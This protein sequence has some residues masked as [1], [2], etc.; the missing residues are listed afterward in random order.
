MTR[1]AYL[2][3]T[4]WTEL[5][6]ENRENLM[7]EINRLIENLGQYKEALE[8]E[9]ALTLKELLKSGR[10]RKEQIDKA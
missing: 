6:L 8:K 1:V 9:D 7:I 10:E 3:E 4:M 2:N 5:F